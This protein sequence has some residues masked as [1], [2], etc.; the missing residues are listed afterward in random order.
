MDTVRLISACVALILVTASPASTLSLPPEFQ[1]HN[2]SALETF[3]E[4]IHG[5]YPDITDLHSI[6]KSVEGEA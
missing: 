3:L 6:G 1:Y 4:D 2:F 5:Q